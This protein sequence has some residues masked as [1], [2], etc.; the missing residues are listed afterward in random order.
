MTPLKMQRICN[1]QAMAEQIGRT[2]EFK[3][4]EKMSD[5]HLFV[6]QERMIEIYNASLIR[7]G[8]DCEL[9]CDECLNEDCTQRRD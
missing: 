9:K 4:L 7:E 6:T 2:I 1:I 5:N 3:D 8:K